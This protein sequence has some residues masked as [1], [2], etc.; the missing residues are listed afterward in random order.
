M[1]SAVASGIFAVRSADKA[2]KG[3]V[4]RSAVCLGQTAGVI[5]EV[6]KYDGIVA[7]S[8]RSAISV[9]S[10]LAKENKAFEYAGKVTK[11]AINNVNP[12]ICASGVIKTAMADDKLK[13][14]IIETAALTTMFAGEDFIKNNYDKIVNSEKCK[15]ILEKASNN[16]ILKPVFEYLE[17]NNLKGKAGMLI[18]G[19]TFVGGSM[20]SYALGQNLGEKIADKV[21]T[22]F[23]I[24]KK[25]NQKA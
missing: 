16:K 3:D 4:G 6:A 23:K 20:S 8:A 7:N 11:F 15:N 24:S 25:I 1:F 17:K 14:G 13:T 12:L 18:K 9:F 2:Q 5:Q 21:E 10:D 22:N 19:L